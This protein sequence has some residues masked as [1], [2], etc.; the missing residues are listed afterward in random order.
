MHLLQRAARAVQAVADDG[1]A[2]LDL[3]SGQAGALFVV[4]AEGAVGVNAVAEA[5]GLAQ[6]A[7]S[8]LMQRLEAQ[9]LVARTPDPDD[10]RAVRLALTA[11]GRA[12]RARAAERAAEFNTRMARGFSAAE[13]ETIA[14][15]LEQTLAL[16]ET[17]DD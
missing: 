13:L 1:L 6:S 3:T 8:V 16:K 11:K 2:D 17:K 14:R 4:P 7:A 15:F 12:L 10:R 5:L 9:G